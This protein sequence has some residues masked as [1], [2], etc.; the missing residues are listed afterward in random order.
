MAG[1]EF[2]DGWKAVG[3][4]GGWGFGS[5]LETQF[6]GGTGGYYTSVT[7]LSK[8]RKFY[9]TQRSLSNYVPRD[10]WPGPLLL[11]WV[12]PPYIA[13]RKTK[14][15][16]SQARDSLSRAHGSW[17]SFFFFLSFDSMRKIEMDVDRVNWWSLPRW[18]IIFNTFNI[19]KRNVNFRL[20]AF[21][22]T[23]PFRVKIFLF[24][25]SY[26]DIIPLYSKNSFV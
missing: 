5:R 18:E 8:L 7:P 16:R 22:L 15:L 9:K 2:A 20:T 6:A 3:W 24:H 11:R 4:N 10:L 25:N 23:I 26:K 19:Y 1:H 12:V 21:L 17:L 14:L 13:S